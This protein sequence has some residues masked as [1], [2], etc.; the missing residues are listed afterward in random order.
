MSVGFH[1]QL[2]S[3]GFG[4]ELMEKFTN[5]IGRKSGNYLEFSTRSAA[6]VQ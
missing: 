1:I 4:V 2:V 5:C 3:W 6:I